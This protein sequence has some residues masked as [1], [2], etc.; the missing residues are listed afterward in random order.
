MGQQFKNIYFAD[1]P[2]ESARE[3]NL[4]LAF[5]DK[6]GA[7]Y[8][9][10]KPLTSHEI[11]ERLGHANHRSLTE[12]A[13]RESLPLNTYCLRRLRDA[14]A[15]QLP[16]TNGELFR[17]NGT[18]RPLIDPIQAT[19]R[20]GQAE[21]L[22]GWYPYLEGYS[23]R[24]VEQVLQEFAPHAERILDPFG[25]TG[26]TPLTAA[27]LGRE[28]FFCE[29]NP[30]LQFLVEAKTLAS[31]LADK[32][33]EE[34]VGRL[35]ELSDDL[36]KRIAECRPDLEL[37]A[38]YTATFGDSQFFDDSVF[39]AVLQTR[40]AIDLLACESPLAAKFFTIAVL[41]SLI[42]TSRLIRRGDVRFKNGAESKRFKIGLTDCIKNQLRL[43][44]H[45]LKLLQP[46]P[47]T[48]KLVCDDARRL[49]HLLPL[50]IDTVV[51]SP[52]YLNGTNYF[53][54]TKIELWFLRCL[55]TAD[56]LAD[57]R[58]RTVT[59]GINDVTNAKLNG[60]FPK[61]ARAL[62]AQ[63]EVSAYDIRIPRMV[64]SYF[65]DMR[66]VF[67]ALK[68]HLTAQATLILD[69]GDSAYGNIHVPTDKLLAE[70]F[71]EMGF[72]LRREV[73]LRKR[74]SRGGFGLRQVLLVFDLP[75]ARVQP[76][77]DRADL[78]P[79]RWEKSWNLFKRDLPHQ[80]EDF[81]KRNWGHPL[82]SLCSYQGKMK[83]SLAHHL[84]KTFVPDGG[85]MLDPFGGVGTIPFEAALEG[86]QNWSFDISPAGYQIATAKVGLLQAA[87][88]ARA[89][90]E[91]ESFIEAGTVEN[92]ELA[93]ARKI[94]FNGPLPDYFSPK[95]FK[96]I[97]L[98]RRFF[99]ERP[100]RSAS[101]SLV[102]ASLLHILHGNRPYALSRRSHP[103]TP[104]APTGPAEFRPLMPRLREKVA[105]SLETPR[106][107]R[108]REGK[109]IVQDATSWWPREVC[110]LD[111]IITSPPF[112]DSTRFY[113][114]N[115]MRLWFCGWEANDFRVQP[116]AYVDER[117][118]QGFEI[119]E[120][121]FRQARER[122]KADGVL[123]LHLGK[124]R[125]CDMAQELVKI[126]VRW[127][128]VADIF[129]E[130]VEHCESHGIRDKG[131]VTAHQFLILQ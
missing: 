77:H 66:A 39:G 24:F 80:A 107:E 48:P 67:G 37:Q 70:I 99:L 3:R 27:K 8:E 34:I 42:P 84:V 116:L 20:G 30:L 89:E 44:V 114:A 76:M 2:A 1:Y 10:I 96:E 36:S 91:L 62:V 15:R 87:E 101:E 19:F 68:K 92:S 113:L 129:T 11:R 93:A 112:F 106:S 28:A 103:I 115:W 23:P 81:A 64:A 131:T 100:P 13:Q 49:Q 17:Q 78:P 21:P 120:P 22:H 90:R 73:I 65:N 88:C 47:K 12:A 119:Y 79:P 52:P 45:D 46:L 61:Q 109:V 7:L 72:S 127:F 128:R 105:R 14:Q 16:K 6:D 71:L 26:T 104:F 122:L 57:F 54:N 43:M 38:A 85:R 50:D 35:L 31:S 111:A 60:D 51:T 18:A 32:Q 102:F 130:T 95:T 82:H 4:T 69:I 55:R 56:D 123:V 126:A 108:F 124:S 86:I 9:G 117:Q 33:R 121:I 97:L 29:L 74:M 53:R 58:L 118:K 83:P 5:G 59:A 94:H 75:K 125:K 40:T 25:G 41:A 63:L 110:D 98:A